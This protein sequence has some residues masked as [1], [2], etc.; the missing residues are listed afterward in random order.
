LLRGVYYDGW[1]PNKARVKYTVEQ[2]VQ[3][4]AA[5]ASI[6]AVQAP[7]TAATI[8][9][10]MADRMSPGQVSETLAELPTDLR[11]AVT[12]T[13]PVGWTARPVTPPPPAQDRLDLLE[14]QIS[15]LTEA[16]RAALP[17]DWRA[18]SPRDPES[19]RPTSAV[20]PDSPT[21]FS[22]PPARNP[23]RNRRARARR[24][25]SAWSCGGEPAVTNAYNGLTVFLCG[26]VM[27]GRGVDQIL[28]HPG[29]V[30]LH[31]A[32]VRDALSYVESAE[33]TN[34]PIPRPVGFSWPWGDAY[35]CSTNPLPTSGSSYLETSVTRSGRVRT[36]QDRALPDESPPT[37]PAS[38]SPGPTL[39]RWRTT[40]Q[41]DFGRPGLYET[42]E[43]MS[44]SGLRVAGAGLDVREARRPAAVDVVGG[45]RVLVFSLAMASSGVPATWAAA[46]G[47]AGIDFVPWLSDTIAAE[48]AERVRRAKRPGDLAI[49]S[50]HWGS[51]WGYH[52]TQDQIRFA[53][54]LI[55][56]G[57]D[58][59]HGHSSHH[60]RTG[61]GVP[62]PTH[63]LWVRRLHHDY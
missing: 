63:P 36:G 30:A 53:H 5:Q 52:V 16:V 15:S 9:E 51:N 32:Y 26:D 56:G 33:A 59:V 48:I 18:V 1:E 50:M 54:G 6:P 12:G 57:V 45:R 40:T 61:R 29:D 25:R 35:G 10:V 55:D 49:L 8:T 17:T 38:P 41:L 39:A 44:D 34:G 43:A 7:T 60:V 4:F 3:R 22:S 11:A 58:L 23:R 19:A 2:Y 46:E 14:D 20:P 24:S 42:L 31:E 28:P 21:R 13:G 47:Q 27:L 37:F 62:R